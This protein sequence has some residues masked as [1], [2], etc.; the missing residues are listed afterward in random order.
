M[1]RKLLDSQAHLF[2]K[3][4][5]LERFYPMYEAADTFLYTP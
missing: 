1:L 3:G 4:G 2:H 5:K